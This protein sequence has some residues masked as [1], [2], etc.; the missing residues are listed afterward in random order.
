[1]FFPVT[2]YLVSNGVHMGS[3]QV[4]PAFFANFSSFLAPVFFMVASPL[5]FGKIYNPLRPA[6]W[7]LVLFL[8]IVFPRMSLSGRNSILWV[9]TVVIFFN[10]SSPFLSA[11]R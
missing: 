1:M 3:N 8:S 10:V 11:L 4:L 2:D 7:W 9:P 5:S 6:M